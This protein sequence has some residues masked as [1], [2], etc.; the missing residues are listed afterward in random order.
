MNKRKARTRHPAERYQGFRVIPWE[1]GTGRA[2]VLGALT[3]TFPPSIALGVLG[4]GCAGRSVVIALDALAR[5]PQFEQEV[6]PSGI[7]FPHDGQHM[8]A[9]CA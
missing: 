5:A 1:L 3:A 8:I 9:S 2:A 6:L 4:T 7:C